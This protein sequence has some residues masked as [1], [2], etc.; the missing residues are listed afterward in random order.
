MIKGSS[1]A[2]SISNFINQPLSHGGDYR[3][4][5]PNTITFSANTSSSIYNSTT[6]QPKSLTT[7]YIIKS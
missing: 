4:N 1:G 3:D 5:A 2:I 6:V 7:I